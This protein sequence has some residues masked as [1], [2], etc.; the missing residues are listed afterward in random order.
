MKIWSLYKPPEHFCFCPTTKVSL[1][2]PKSTTRS[3]ALAAVP[4]RPYLNEHRVTVR[5][6]TSVEGMRELLLSKVHAPCVSLREEDRQA[7]TPDGS[8][9]LPSGVESCS[10]LQGEMQLAHGYAA[11]LFFLPTWIRSFI[12]NLSFQQQGLF[13][14]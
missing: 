14:C 7:E 11:E 13:A 6:P 5:E 10:V 12:K 3:I 4:S 9:S 8:S 2:G 1:W